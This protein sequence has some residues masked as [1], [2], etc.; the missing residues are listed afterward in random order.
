[1]T[2][3][4]WLAVLILAA[5]L[6]LVLALDGLR[7]LDDRVAD[8]ADRRASQQRLKRELERLP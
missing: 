4:D 2:G 6:A 5:A 3:D 8:R 7:R 1:M